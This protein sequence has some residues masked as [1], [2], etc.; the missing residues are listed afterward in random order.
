M[1]II[2]AHFYPEFKLKP[3]QLIA[4]NIIIFVS[5]FHGSELFILIIYQ[6]ATINC[7]IN[8]LFTLYL[9]VY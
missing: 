5:S 7:C 6:Y 8:M 3:Q 2:V 9:T 4:L 1:K